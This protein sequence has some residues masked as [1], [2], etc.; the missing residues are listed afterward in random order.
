MM[1]MRIHRL[2]KHRHQF[3]LFDLAA[4]S[5]FASPA[6]SFLS[7]VHHR[8]AEDPADVQQAWRRSA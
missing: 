7:S 5:F 8:D 4:T 2:Y 6:A 1:C 3:V